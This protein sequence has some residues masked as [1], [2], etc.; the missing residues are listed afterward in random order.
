MRD[1][2]A[3]LDDAVRLTKNAETEEEIAQ[4]ALGRQYEHNYLIARQT[5]GSTVAERLFSKANRSKS[6][7]STATPDATPAQ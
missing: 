3:A 5:I 2:L 7:D 6:E 4:G 1:A